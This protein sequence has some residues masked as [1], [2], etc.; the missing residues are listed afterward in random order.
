M[1]VDSFVLT[2]DPP[3][4]SGGIVVLGE[5]HDGGFAVPGFPAEIEFGALLELALD[6]G[7]PK[8]TYEVQLVVE[9]SQRENAPQTPVGEPFTVE[10]LEPDVDWWGPRQELH[11][12]H[13]KL[14]FWDEFEGYLVVRV[15]G[16]EIGEKALRVL[17]YEIPDG[18][19]GRS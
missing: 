16:V 14:T 10:A 11:L 5:V 15:D 18:P 17:H 9:Y 8:G 6:E 4:V 12:L 13:I 2:T 19:E 1:Y 7:D 3:Q